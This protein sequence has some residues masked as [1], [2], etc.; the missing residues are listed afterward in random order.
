MK[1]VR[2]P[3]LPPSDDENDEEDEEDEE[4]EEEEDDE[5]DET[6]WELISNRFSRSS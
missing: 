5:D 1:R 2:K 3:G 4:A 6:A